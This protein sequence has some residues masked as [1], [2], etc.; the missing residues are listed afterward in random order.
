[1]ISSE[2]D[3]LGT[4]PSAT[5]EGMESNINKILFLNISPAR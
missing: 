2:M 1:M 4:T 5:T 3:L